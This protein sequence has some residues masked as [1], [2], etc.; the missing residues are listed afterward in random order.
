MRKLWKNLLGWMAPAL[1]AASCGLSHPDRLET[2]LELAGDNRAELE[3]VLRHYAGD[4]LKREAARFLIENMPYHYGR[5][6]YYAAP[7]RENIRP[8]FTTFATPE[9]VSRYHDSLTGEGYQPHTEVRMDV[10]AVDSRFLIDHIEA[11]FRIKDRP[12]VREVPFDI[13]CEYILP[14][15]AQTEELSSL[16]TRMQELFLPLLDSAGVK[17]PLEACL[18]LNDKLKEVIRYGHPNLPL[19]P[20]VEETLHFGQ[21]ECDAMC[22]L[23]V[24]VMRACGIPVSVEQTIWPKMDLGHKWCAV[25]NQGT[26]HCFG[27]GE[28]QP[29]EYR[30]HLAEVTCL[31]PVKVYRSRFSPRKISLPAKDDGYTTYL[32]SPLLYDVTGEYID[33]PVSIQVAADKEV[34]RGKELIYLCIYNHY[35]WVP[36]AIGEREGRDCRLGITAGD[37]IFLVMHAPDGKRLRSLTAPFYVGWNNVIHKLIPD[38]LNRQ[39][40]CFPKRPK[41]LESLYTLHYWDVGA[42]EFVPL[43]A[44]EDTRTSQTYDNIPRN[45]LLW[46]TIPEKI[47]NQRIAVIRDSLLNYY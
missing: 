20:K 9:E 47:L 33:R 30:E 26:F 3:Q 13:F 19:Y 25:W 43:Q 34:G 18:L 27:P 44:S 2:A 46:F 22:D 37:N 14:Y 11:A 41:K 15:R 16:R 32:K 4:S 8:D 40:F 38:T 35:N 17:T 39:T 21:G 36:V 1:L 23:G 12:W 24:T 29:G 5:K 45:A 31:R 6:Q 28:K 7:G 42:D 10:R